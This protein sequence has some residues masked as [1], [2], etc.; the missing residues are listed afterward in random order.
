MI[1]GFDL[2]GSD[3]APINELQALEL[4]K[5]DPVCDL[6]VVGRGDYENEVQ[7]LGYD[8]RLADE[9][10]GMHE[11]PAVAVRQKR[12]SSL[13]ILV[14]M[15]KNKKLDAIVSAGNTG[16]ILGFSMIHLRTIEDVS[17][18]G[19]AITVPTASGYSVMIDI[20]ANIHPKTIDYYNYGL[21]GAAFAEIVFSKKKPRVAMLNIGVESVKGDEI[22][23]KAYQN[24]QTSGLNFI[25]NIEG[26]DIMKGFA[27]VIVCDGFTGNVILKFSEGM[28][29]IIWKML[30]ETVDA[31]V[32]RRFGRYLVKPAVQDLK[33]KFNYEEYGGGILLGVNG[34]VIVCHGHS[35]P[36]ALK[37]A[38]GLA[39]TCAERNLTEEI[40]K[41]VAT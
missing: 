21:M 37:N 2:M 15:L 38:I 28:I 3:K 35:S 9:V 11:I 26:N 40:R 20:G 31:V 27:D 8:F 16:A 39:K 24:L 13:G 4:F 7:D 19:L 12:N 10:V 25:G 14:D 29:D 41:R 5:E 6:L 32:R 18:A 34:V 36:Q 30:R 22:R 17:K 33:A 1:V 23:Q